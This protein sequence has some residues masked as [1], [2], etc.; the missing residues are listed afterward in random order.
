M[1]SKGGNPFLMDDYADQADTAGQQA[2]NPFL[3]DFGSAAS[4]GGGGGENPF[5]NFGADQGY[6][7]PSTI[8]STNPFASF[9]VETTA[10]SSLFGV[11]TSSTS[12]FPMSMQSD[13]MFSAENTNLFGQPEPAQ[14]N[15]QQTQETNLFGSPEEVSKPI[16]EM[17]SFAETDTSKQGMDQKGVKPP[18]MRP[19]PPR[20]HPP[21]N[22]KDLILSVTG[23][24][25]ATSNHLL[26]RLQATRTPSPTLMH[27]PSPTPEH[28]FADLLDVDGSVPELAQDDNR[29]H[30]TMNNS[31]IMNLFDAPSGETV[32]CSASDMIF[33]SPKTETTLFASTETSF[34]TGATCTQENP[35]A[36]LETE[37]PQG[38]AINASDYPTEGAATVVEKR[39]S[40]T[41]ETPFSAN[42]PFTSPD[43]TRV[44]TMTGFSATSETTFSDTIGAQLP[45]STFSTLGQSPAMFSAVEPEVSEPSAEAYLSSAV[46]TF[47]IA[48]PLY[49]SSVPEMV[50]TSSPFSMEQHAPA[51][52]S[53]LLGDF[54][55][56]EQAPSLISTSPEPAS[57]FPASGV[58][59]TE[60][61]DE[62]TTTAKAIE[63]TG[64]AFDAFA[65][66]FDKAAEPEPPGDAFFDAFGAGQTAM[67]TSSDGKSTMTSQFS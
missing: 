27:S 30:E 67:D 34:F 44:T 40:T 19:P 65:S 6:Q 35:F 57:E 55:Q 52:A 47:G 39:L 13:D 41:S 10:P 25:D 59:Q 23:T 53:D 58:Y 3:Q 43:L 62:F 17:V 48:E 38:D 45:S 37:V 49:T 29:P 14:Q 42:S 31:D 54:S 18:P 4:S 16:P 64:D 56:S 60:H 32:P 12:T 51:L 21:K 24:M 1:D 2:S 46:D 66:K 15:Q 22:T 63:S 28:S 50:S 8:D 61:L 9:G 36:E 7:P 11:E 26:D 20:P 5:L 33:S